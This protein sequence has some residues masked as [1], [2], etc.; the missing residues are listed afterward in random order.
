MVL[1]IFANV[2]TDSFDGSSPSV[3]QSGAYLQ[4]NAA[5]G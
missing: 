3:L 2:Q 1:K 4:L 5:A